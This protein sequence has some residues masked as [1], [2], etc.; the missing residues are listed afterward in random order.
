MISVDKAIANLKLSAAEK[1][2]FYI[3]RN[4]N[5]DTKIFD[6]TYKQIQKDLNVSPNEISNVFHKL[7]SNG[8]LIRAGFGKW[9]VPAVIGYECDDEDAWTINV[10]Q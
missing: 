8:T 4:T 1:I 5:G 7:E 3:L 10:A 2:V 6:R 9:F